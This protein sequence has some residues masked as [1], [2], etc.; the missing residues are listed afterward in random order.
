M[1]IIT[2]TIHSFEEYVYDSFKDIKQDCHLIYQEDFVYRGL[3]SASFQLETSLIRNCRSNMNFE[4]NLLRNFAKHLPTE[5][6]QHTRS[7]WDI[8]ILGQHHGLPTRLLDWSYSPLIAL[9]FAT[10]SLKY[11]NEDAV[12]WKASVMDANKTLP[13]CFT[14]TLLSESKH[15]FTLEDLKNYTKSSENELQYFEDTIKNGFLFF[16]PPNI[17]SRIAF[18]WSIFSLTKSKINIEEYFSKNNI[19]VY[20]YIIPH[21]IK[22]HLRDILDHSNISERVLFPG[23][24]GLC[25]WLARTYYT[26]R[27]YK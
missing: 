26:E 22:V 11:M 27:N 12:I 7:I 21:A 4:K 6:R 15:I 5:F 19:T 18:Q 13:F 2:K 23:L 20:K 25:S 17:D 8:M 16:A 10:S 9:H 1:P 3:P 14:D 24:E